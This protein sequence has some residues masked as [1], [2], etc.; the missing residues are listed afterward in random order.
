MRSPQGAVRDLGAAG[1]LL[2]NLLLA[3][4][5][6]AA[7]AHPWLLALLVAEA[8]A[9][10]IPAGLP[11]LAAGHLCAVLAPLLYLADRNR[12]GGFV[13]AALTVPAHWFLV[14]AATHRAIIE[15]AVDPFRWNKTDHGGLIGRGF[16]PAGGSA[17][18]GDLAHR[19]RIADVEAHQ[20]A[21]SPA[22]AFG[23]A[24]VCVRA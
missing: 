18:S 20:P 11:V 1:F 7:V 10:A 22:A 8:L 6:L 24:A 23:G 19:R 13:A 14:S 3:G 21:P 4:S 12:L 9:G 5:V 2:M 16:S 17:S 15:F